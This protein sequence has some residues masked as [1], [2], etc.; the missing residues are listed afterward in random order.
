MQKPMPPHSVSQFAEADRLDARRKMVST[1]G[2]CV[3]IRGAEE[4][5]R[6]V[7]DRWTV[8]DLL[9][10]LDSHDD[11]AVAAAAL[12]LGCIGDAALSPSLAPLLHHADPVVSAAA[13]QALWSVWFRS[14]SAL[15]QSLICQAVCLLEGD[16]WDEAA[17]VLTEIVTEEPG[18]AEAW[19]QRGIARYLAGRLCDSIADWKRVIRLNPHH[20]GAMA[21]LGHCFAL[22]GR[23]TDALDCYHAALHIHP[24]MDGIRQAIQQLRSVRPVETIGAPDR[25]A[26]L[27][28][29]V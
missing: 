10:C 28:S 11:E 2:W 9:G 20:F 26:A 4:I 3:R 7:A 24:R 16:R 1:A 29:V 17:A 25:H 12:C 19:N 23:R 27:L 14:G 5:W 6:H 21:G 18:F 22:L 13:E 8:E 15:A